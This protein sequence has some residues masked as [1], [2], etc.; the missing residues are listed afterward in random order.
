MTST[1][2]FCRENLPPTSNLHKRN[3]RK[4]SIN[5]IADRKLCFNCEFQVDK[6]R[7]FGFEEKSFIGNS[8]SGEMKQPMVIICGLSLL[9]MNTA[10]EGRGKVSP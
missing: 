4:M 8:K 5:A 6:R 9:I 2:R 10:V 3:G 7:K 1:H